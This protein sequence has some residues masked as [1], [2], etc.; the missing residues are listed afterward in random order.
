MSNQQVINELESEINSRKNKI[1][2]YNVNKIQVELFGSKVK[3]GLNKSNNASI[4]NNQLRARNNTTF[5]SINVENLRTNIQGNFNDNLFEK[6]LSILEQ[7]N[8]STDIFSEVL[9]THLNIITNLQKNMNKIN[10]NSNIKKIPETIRDLYKKYLDYIQKVV[11]VKVWKDLKILELF[12][13]VFTIIIPGIIENIKKF[14]IITIDLNKKLEK[15]LGE[16]TKEDNNKIQKHINNIENKINECLD[17]ILKKINEFLAT[18]K[19]TGVGFNNNMENFFRNPMTNIM[20]GGESNVKYATF[21]SEDE[22]EDHIDNLRIHK[23]NFEKALENNINQFDDL[24][25]L[26]IEL[27]DDIK[28]RTE[29]VVEK[30]TPYIDIIGLNDHATNLLNENQKLIESLKTY[31]NRNKRVENTNKRVELE[32]DRRQKQINNIKEENQSERRRNRKKAIDL[33][34]KERQRR[35]S[36]ATPQSSAAQPGQQQGIQ[37]Q[38][39][40]KSFSTNKPSSTNE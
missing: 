36:Q 17:K 24:C 16:I 23:E 5:E 28:D 40:N 35:I 30:L 4:N 37:L 12:Q 20:T 6:V 25:K 10:T 33:E 3:F 34:E 22:L 11:I 19:T 2:E 32:R 8:I 27:L 7:N 38:V 14:K 13:F 1:K 31:I 15:E 26:F 18:K 29:K 9:D 39:T 21:T